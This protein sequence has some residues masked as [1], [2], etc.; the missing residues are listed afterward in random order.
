MLIWF[1]LLFIDEN[2]LGAEEERDVQKSY[3]IENSADLT[4]EAIYDARF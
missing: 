2:N 4:V 3:W 1:D